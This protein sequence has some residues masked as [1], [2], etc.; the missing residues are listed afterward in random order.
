MRPDFPSQWSLGR[1]PER[2][3]RGREAGQRGTVSQRRKRGETPSSG[4]LG[5]PR[6]VAWR[7][8]PFQFFLASVPTHDGG[9]DRSRRGQTNTNGAPSLHSSRQACYSASQYVL[10]KGEKHSHA[11]LFALNLL[12][13]PRTL[14]I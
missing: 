3:T 13:H 2:S 7:C 9:Q 5:S 1:S 6:Q 4:A 14:F 10:Y 8:F 11:V 12:R